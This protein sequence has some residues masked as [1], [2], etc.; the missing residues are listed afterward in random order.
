ML[1]R[2]SAAISRY[3]IAGNFLGLPAITVTVRIHPLSFPGCFFR[4]ARARNELTRFFLAKPLG[5][6]RQGRPP[7]RAPVHRPAVGGGD[8]AAFSLRHAGQH[9]MHLLTT[10][11]PS[12]H[13]YLFSSSLSSGGCGCLCRKRALRAAGNPW[14]PLISSAR[15]SSFC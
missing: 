10:S 15:K 6:V 3:S 13:E 8:A 4:I 14:C 11:R 5:R 7:R 9:H 2:K 12:R 1:D